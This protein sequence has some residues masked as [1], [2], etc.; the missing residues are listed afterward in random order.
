MSD[1]IAHVFGKPVVHRALGATFHL[2]RLTPAHAPSLERAV[3]LVRD[4]LGPHLRQE[5]ASFLDLPQGFQES[6]LEW[7]PSFCEQLDDAAKTGDVD[8]DALTAQLARRL[9]TDFHVVAHGGEL[10]FSCSPFRF[11]FWAEL[12]DDDAHPS[13]PGLVSAYSVLE[14]SVPT[15]WDLADFQARTLAL[16]ASLP[17]RWGVAGLTY[18]TFLPCDQGRSFDRI[19]AHARRH[20]GFDAPFYVRNVVP[21]FDAL[22]TVSWITLLGPAL[23]ARL[24]E[25]PRSTGLVEVARMG[26]L[27]GLR[28][29]ARP[30]G[31]DV[32]RLHYPAAYVEADRMLRELR[33]TAG[34]DLVFPGPWEADEITSWLRRFERRLT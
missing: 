30:E 9:R 2:E 13:E 32:N 25:A 21:F 7:V 19:Y 4:W 20:P 1:A 3:G 29:G 31:G 27:L 33:A 12:P 11:E 14:V 23:A 18:S 6:T 10:P 8:V 34:D 24:P 5:H 22:R 17:V 16:A 26:E 15:S 28:A